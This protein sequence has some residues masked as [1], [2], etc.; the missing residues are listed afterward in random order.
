VTEQIYIHSKLL[1]VDDR[2]VI[3]GSANIN[4]RS[5]LGKR[6]VARFAPRRRPLFFRSLFVLSFI[7]WLTTTSGSRRDSE[8]CVMIND[9]DFV[10]S[11]MN[12]ACVVCRN[13]NDH[14]RRCRVLMSCARA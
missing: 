13:R 11:R 5:M 12:G 8:I 3:C 10:D 4:D 1:I 9:T 6:S 14:W 2:L 7:L